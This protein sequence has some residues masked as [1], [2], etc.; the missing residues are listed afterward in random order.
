MQLFI[1]IFLLGY[2]AIAVIATRLIV[3]KFYN[4]H[5]VIVGNVRKIVRA[6]EMGSFTLTHPNASL[7]TIW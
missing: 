6:Y 4:W 5:Y 3:S 1:L 2:A 7:A